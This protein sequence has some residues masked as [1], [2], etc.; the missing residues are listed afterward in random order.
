M[1]SKKGLFCVYGV[2][3]I[4]SQWFHAPFCYFSLPVEFVYRTFKKKLAGRILYCLGGIFLEDLWRHKEKLVLHSPQSSLLSLSPSLCF[5]CSLYPPASLCLSLESPETQRC[6]AGV[7]HI[8]RGVEWNRIDC[9]L[10]RRDPGRGLVLVSAWKMV[11]VQLC[12]QVKAS[13]AK[14]QAT[15]AQHAT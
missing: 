14:S 9:G 5:I 12:E 11:G 13:L 7:K 3:L 4:R 8:E 1:N 10:F 6:T 15:F 2:P